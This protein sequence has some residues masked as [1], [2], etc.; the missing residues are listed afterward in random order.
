MK[1]ISQ[2]SDPEWIY[3]EGEFYRHHHLSLVEAADEPLIARLSAV[4]SATNRTKYG[5]VPAG[6]LLC[7]SYRAEKNGDHCEIQ[8]TLR[9]SSVG[10]GCKIINTRSGE[11]LADIPQYAAVD[12]SDYLPRVAPFSCC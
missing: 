4:L 2:Q 12:M 7:T 6:K 8:V 1:L 3:E 11:R 9:E 10:Y 5:G